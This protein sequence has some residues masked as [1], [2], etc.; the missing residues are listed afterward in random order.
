MLRHLDFAAKHLEERG[1]A[2]PVSTND[3]DF[4]IF[5]LNDEVDPREKF[6]SREFNPAIGNL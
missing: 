5:I 4:L 3:R 1:L 2:A 6:L